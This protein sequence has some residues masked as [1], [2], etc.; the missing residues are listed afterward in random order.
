MALFKD[1]PKPLT[2]ITYKDANLYLDMVTG[3]SASDILH[4]CNQTLM[5][6]YQSNKPEM[7]LPRLAK[8][9]LLQGFACDQIMD[10]LMTLQCLGISV[11]TKNYMFGDIQA[12]VT[13]KTIPS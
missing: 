6:W 7:G 1:I 12:V 10:L 5:D 2:T 11:Y 8:S 13:I 4:F 9:L 3:R